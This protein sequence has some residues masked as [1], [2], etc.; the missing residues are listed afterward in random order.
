MAATISSL[1]DECLENIVSFV[2]DPFTFGSIA[3]TCKRFLRM[4]E[5]DRRVMH[6]NLLKSKAEYY[7]KLWTAHSRRRL[8]NRDHR[9]EDIDDIDDIHELLHECATLTSSKN[10]VTYDK[11]MAVWERNGPVAAKLF[12][13]VRDFKC[14][15]YNSLSCEKRNITLHLP[16][17]KKSMIINANLDRESTWRCTP[18]LTINCGDLC[19]KSNSGSFSDA[20]GP[21][22][23]FIHWTKEEVERA[24]VPMKSVIKLLQ[25]ELG[26]TIPPLTPYFFLW[27]CHFFPDK[28]DLLDDNRLR[29]KDASRNM[30]PTR[31][32]VDMAIADYNKELRFEDSL[33]EMFRKWKSVMLQR[34]TKMLESE[35]L[36]QK[37]PKK[38]EETI[39]LLS[40]RSEAK[41]LE[42]L[43]E[44]H[45]RFSSIANY[46][47]SL[48]DLDNKVFFDLLSRTS[49]EK[50]STYKSHNV[51]P[52]K[53]FENL[54]M[55]RC[56]GGKYMVVWGAIHGDGGHSWEKI[57]LEFTLPDENLV[58]RVESQFDLHILS[59]VT[60][61]LQKG[62]NHLSLTGQGY[63]PTISNF[64][65]AVYFLKA[66][67]FTVASHIAFHHWDKPA[68]R[69]TLSDDH[70]WSNDEYEWLTDES[71]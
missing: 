4:T 42:R 3:L 45:R 29:F 33:Q 18:S 2:D 49:L 11:V 35:Q 50:S 59:P 6:T 15:V 28:S 46:C 9:Y 51:I 19:V 52:I 39:R 14:T 54:V 61:L 38:I 58:L 20:S 66:L 13:W 36:L 25:G 31:T 21:L 68:P 37:I 63:S 30:K 22:D 57:E 44:H 16:K 53:H 43:K 34:N 70:E 47:D 27:L 64:H 69:Y 40:L 26:E 65:T 10:A 56:I 1:P 60:Y 12:T 23:N 17:C 5:N 24:T 7:I 55:Y 67:D 62:I 41:V 48:Q 71:M 8:V 32:S